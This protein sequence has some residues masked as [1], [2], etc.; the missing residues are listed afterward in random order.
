MQD[1][2]F[3]SQVEPIINKL[4]KKARAAEIFLIIADQRPDNQDFPMQTRSNLD[5]RLVLNVADKGTSKIALNEEGAEEHLK[6]GQIFAK[7][8]KYPTPIFCQVPYIS[9]DEMRDLVQ[10]IIQDIER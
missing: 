5:N 9:P 8:G 3:K 6:H 4:A 2:P 7:T 1:P 10:I